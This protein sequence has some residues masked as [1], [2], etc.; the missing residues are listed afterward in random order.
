MRKVVFLDVD[1]VLHPFAGS[2]H[3]VPSAM[4][5]LAELI[6][7]TGASIVL[8]SSWQATPEMMG[9]V[10]AEFARY[11]IAACAGRTVPGAPPSTTVAGRVREIQRWLAVHP[12]AVDSWVALDDLA[13]DALGERFVQTDAETGLTSELASVAAR[14]LNNV[15]GGGSVTPGASR[16]HWPAGRFALRLDITAWTVKA[17]IERIVQQHLSGCRPTIDYVTAEGN[18]DQLCEGVEGSV[19]EDE[20][21][22]FS[23]YLPLTL[24]ELPV[25]IGSGTVLD[26]EDTACGRL[27]KVTVCHDPA[28]VREESLCGFVVEAEPDCETEGN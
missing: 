10:D 13:L 6:A 23:R 12:D 19:D 28:L 21:E 18:G 4:R 24:T 17:L 27:L 11:A 1:G 20:A 15:L 3:F 14:I 22:K 2:E 26:I 25:P 7:A 8:S 9:L 16:P 5:A